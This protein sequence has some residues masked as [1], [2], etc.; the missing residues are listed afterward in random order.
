M[1]SREENRR[2]A[3]A[4][5]EAMGSGVG[6]PQLPNDPADG[7]SNFNHDYAACQDMSCV[8]CD[9]Y[10]DGYTAGK[11]AAYFKVRNWHPKQH[12]PSCGRNPCI[13]ARS[14]IEKTGMPTEPKTDRPRLTQSGT[15]QFA[16][17][18][19]RVS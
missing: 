6:D 15:Q 11:E 18:T 9:A 2:L 8:R 19:I 10:G 7:P 1:T 12:A 13:A 16:K 4:Y 14:V 17:S 5:A 3:E